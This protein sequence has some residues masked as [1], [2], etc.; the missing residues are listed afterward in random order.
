MKAA[1]LEEVATGGGPH[2]KAVR[3][4]LWSKN[5]FAMRYQHVTT[6]I[7]SHNAFVIHPKGDIQLAGE[8]ESAMGIAMDW[9]RIL[10]SHGAN[11]RTNCMI[12]LSNSITDN[13]FVQ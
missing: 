1:Y 3:L 7:L 6:D 11:I 9:V 4:P 13:L 8:L 2:Q 10:A 5:S 12:L